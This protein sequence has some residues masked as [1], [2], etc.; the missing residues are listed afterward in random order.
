MFSWL[1]EL[2]IALLKFFVTETI[3]EQGKPTKAS[4]SARLPPYLHS[5][6]L[7]RMRKYNREQEGSIPRP[8][9]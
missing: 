1:I 9:D 2:L 6:F 5:R 3:R 8:P 4:D 7:D